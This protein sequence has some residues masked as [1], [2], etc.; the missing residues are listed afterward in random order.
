MNRSLKPQFID[1]HNWYYEE[2]GHIIVVHQ[3]LVRG[4]DLVKQTDQ[5][6]IPAAALAESLERMGFAKATR[7]SRKPKPQEAPAP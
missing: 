4:T 5:I 3:V 7:R 6:K 1:R 2:Q